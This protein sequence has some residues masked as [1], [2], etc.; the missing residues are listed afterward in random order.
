MSEVSSNRRTQR[1]ELIESTAPVTSAPISEAETEIDLLELFFR[2]IESWKIICATAIAGAIVMGVISFFFITPQYEATSKLYILN[3]NDSAI[4][5]SDL[6]IGSY[7]TKDY[8]EVFRTW[9]VHERVIQNLGLDYTYDQLQSILTVG[10]PSDTRILY[11]TA[12][13]PDPQLST[14][15]ANEYATVARQYISD[16]MATEEPNIISIALKPTRPVSPNKTLN[17][18]I[19][20]MLGAILMA[21]IITVRFIMDDKIKTSDD[22]T[23]YLDLPTL[24][25]VPSEHGHHD[26]D[27]SRRAQ[28]AS[29]AKRKKG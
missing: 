23:K 25:I 10:N 11:I 28:K 3:S 6:Q 14:N 16:M 2:L 12:K 7:L 4:N 18:I 24:A 15:I 5:L 1:A 26:E 17:V 29:R 20:F 19:G 21:G 8:Q 27:D 9:E 22:I 13:T